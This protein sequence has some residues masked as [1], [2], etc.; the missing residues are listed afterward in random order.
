[1]TWG[2]DQRMWR[3]EKAGGLEGMRW[4][5]EA[6]QGKAR[7]VKFKVVV[8][9]WGISELESR[10]RYRDL[11]VGAAS[12]PARPL[13]NKYIYSNQERGFAERTC[14]RTRTLRTGERDEQ[15]AVSVS[16]Q[17]QMD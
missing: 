14:C 12:C 4:C 7:I 10:S 3:R 9:C 13:K 1:M 15:Q 6:R 16:R 11:G 8:L 2:Y 5:G 17:E